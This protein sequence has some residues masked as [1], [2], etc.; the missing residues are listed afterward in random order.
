MRLNPDKGA[1][2]AAALAND[3]NGPLVDIEKVCNTHFLVCSLTR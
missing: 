3:E 1:E 2:F